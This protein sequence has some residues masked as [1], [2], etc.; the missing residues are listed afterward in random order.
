MKI[1]IT[2]KQL[3]ILREQI[4]VNDNNKKDLGSIIK[5]AGYQP[6]TPEYNIALFIGN[7]EVWSPGTRSFR[8]N[9]PG[10]LSG[11]DFKDIDPNVT[12]EPKGTY[13]KFST[14]ELGVK[15]LVEKKIKKWSNGKMPITMGNQTLIVKNKGGEKYVQGQKPTVAQFFYTY[16]PPNENDTEL[17]INSFLSKVGGTDRNTI[18]LDLLSN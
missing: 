6:G 17:Y 10:N 8:N 13:A 9:N 15:A 1:L 7:H 4:S 18:L 3:F 11:T 14:P 5:M 2:E 16:A 12:L